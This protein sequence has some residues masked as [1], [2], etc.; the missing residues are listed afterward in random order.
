MLTSYQNDLD[1]NYEIVLLSIF[2]TSFIASPYV[3]EF[4][5]SWGWLI[6]PLSSILDLFPYGY[7]YIKY[8]YWV[9]VKSVYS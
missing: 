6:R 5:G 9:T 2:L 4:S 3:A 7:I 1:E 8:N